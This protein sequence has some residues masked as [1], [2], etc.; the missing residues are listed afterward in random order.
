PTEPPRPAPDVA[1]ELSPAL[2]PLAWWLGDWD[3]E[4]GS[5]SEHWVAAA[6]AIY[7]VAMSASSGF[8]VMIVDDGEGPGKPDGVLR[9]IVFPDG[10]RAVEFRKR[11]LGERAALFASDA[12]DFPKTLDYRRDGEALVAEI[13]GGK[14][15][16][17]RFRR[18]RAH[19]APEL[20]AADRA[21][22][23]DTGRRGVD[24]W[25]A[26]FDPGGSML[27]QGAK[28]AG[29]QIGEVMR[30]L[31]TS[32]RLA[33]APIAS[34]R[35]EALGFT[36]GKATFTGAK[37]EDSWRSTYVTIWRKQPDGSWKVLFDT[38]RV[39]QE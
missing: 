26:A 6:G 3:V 36:V 5:G 17:F 19:P 34:G 18:G 35:T 27:R 37:P 30:P 12:H 11:T 21:F 32:G 9:F 33:W 24:G 23:D 25:V 15:E 7:G 29:A 4:N 28:V 39:V 20:E 8:D 1:S 31:L 16:R 22:S 14:N 38:G 2:A 10:E 13:G